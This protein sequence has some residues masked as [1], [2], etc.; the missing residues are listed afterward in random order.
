MRRKNLDCSK[1][2][3]QMVLLIAALLVSLNLSA[4]K[5]M[6]DGMNYFLDPTK[7]TAQTYEGYQVV[8]TGDIVIPEKIT[9]EGVEYTVT[10]IGS[11]TFAESTITSLTLP[12]TIKKIGT[13]AFEKCTTLQELVVPNSVTEVFCAFERF[14]GLKH[15][16][17][18]YGVDYVDL[19][20]CASL[21]TL[22]V[23]AATP[24]PGIKFNQ[25]A[26]KTLKVYVPKGQKE[27]Y[28]KA[29]SFGYEVTGWQDMN[30]DNI[31]EDPE[32]EAWQ[33]I[34]LHIGKGGHVLFNGTT[35]PDV[36]Y[37]YEYYENT[38][39]VKKGDRMEI[40]FV[41]DDGFVK[42]RYTI[43]PGHNYTA[44]DIIS[45]DS[46]EAFVV[47]KTDMDYE[48][49]GYFIAEKDYYEKATIGDLNYKIFTF[50]HTAEVTTSA[51]ESEVS[52]IYE[53]YNKPVI[54]IPESVIYNGEEYPV[55]S[56][57]VS[58]FTD[59]QT[60]RVVIPPSVTR[61][62]SY[63]FKR[64]H[65]N[66][67]E[68]PATVERIDDY[69]FTASVM[70]SLILPESIDLTTL[71]FMDIDMGAYY[72][73]LATVRYI[74]LPKDMTTIADKMF[75]NVDLS[76]GIEMSEALTSIGVSAF[77][78]SNLRSIHLPEGLTYI[79]SRAFAEC[80][81]LKS[82]TIPAGVGKITSCLF[83]NTPLDTLYMMSPIPPEAEVPLFVDNN[84]DKDPW[85]NLPVL[86]VPKGSKELYQNAYVWSFFDRII[87]FDTAADINGPRQTSIGVEGYY[88]LYGQRLP[89]P[90]KGIVVVRSADGK[91]QKKIFR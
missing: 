40:T 89:M 47:E 9:Y 10:E 1:R 84:S 60:E 37:E 7:Q 19:S 57:G 42:W 64:F 72:A 77:E 23:N 56:I 78:R 24:D 8:Y 30:P 71:P 59:S 62:C 15:L 55:T 25:Y 41:P 12:N 52:L 61:L 17:L 87:E 54:E 73:P 6:V 3:R 31:I 70:D 81:S 53:G 80:W 44:D 86:A 28:A 5:V 39:G 11:R 33:K 75:M 79:G 65:T 50:S 58:A 29:K 2:M 27:V 35:L 46:N 48:V 49:Y 36:P 16:T 21:E 22:R 90:R 34:E 4:Q 88:N 82:I 26:V 68:I 38:L 83:A 74:R 76:K 63:A 18:P 85:A 51:L 14:L 67:L 13:F 91:V 32:M 20:D 69:C 43:L 66:T 45:P